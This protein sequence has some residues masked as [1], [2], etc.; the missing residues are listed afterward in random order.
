MVMS[1]SVR[2]SI[3]RIQER[4]FTE[5]DVSTLIIEMRNKSGP[6]I[7]EAGNLIAHYYVFCPST[8]GEKNTAEGRR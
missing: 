1:A 3:K 5:A 4:S 6:L 7:H 2:A 8:I